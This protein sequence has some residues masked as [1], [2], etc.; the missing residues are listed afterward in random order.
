MIERVLLVAWKGAAATGWVKTIEAAGFRVFLEDTTGE[1]AW[2]TAKERG[3][4][5]VIIDGQ[6]KPSHGRNTGNMLRDTAKTREIPI[7]WTNLNPDDAGQVQVDVRPDILLAA[8]TDALQAVAAVHYL[9]DQEEQ[10]E[11]SAQA[12]AVAFSPPA[13]ENGALS[14]SSPS[15]ANGTCSVEE[16]EEALQSPSKP[17]AAS[18]RKSIASAQAARSAKKPGSASTARAKAPARS[19]SGRS[20]SSSRK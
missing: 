7:I 9:R 10:S 15:P 3:I 20:G 2:R 4:H 13:P 5:V 14:G 16:E 11:G 17:K 8:P 6:K 1:R 12:I 19:T 18:G